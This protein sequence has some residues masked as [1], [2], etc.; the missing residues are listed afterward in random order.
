MKKLI[1]LILALA[2]ILSLISCGTS[3]YPSVDSTEE[4]LRVI[5][6]YSLDSE[7]YEV[8]YEL[9]RAFFLCGKRCR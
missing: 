8:K 4:E 6:T 2:A 5:M 1:S 9:Y 3:E 7:K